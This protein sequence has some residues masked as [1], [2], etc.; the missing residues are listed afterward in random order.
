MKLGYAEIG[1]NIDG[2]RIAKTYSGKYGIITASEPY[3]LC[4]DTV[5]SEHTEM[6]D[7]MIWLKQ[8]KDNTWVLFNSG[9]VQTGYNYKK[10]IKDPK[11]RLDSTYVFLFSKH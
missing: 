6:K 10:Y 7:S 9:S 1:E 11:D 8:V 4:A 3:D 2:Y 5:Y